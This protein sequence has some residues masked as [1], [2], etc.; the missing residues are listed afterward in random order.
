M[1]SILLPAL[2]LLLASC[3]ST[4]PGPA[5]KLVT[6]SPGVQIR[7][8]DGTPVTHLSEARLSP[9]PHRIVLGTYRDVAES[10][11]GRLG[12]AGQTIGQGIDDFRSRR[13]SAGLDLNAQSGATYEARL[14]PN[15][16]PTAYEIVDQATGEV[17][18]RTIR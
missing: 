6:S 18:S 14:V 1:K 17:V 16:S 2:S 7:S 4:P 10:S 3:V 12:I 15:T 9:G 11:M 5:A 13:A 8:I